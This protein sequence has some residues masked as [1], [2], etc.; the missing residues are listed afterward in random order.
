VRGSR[1]PAWHEHRPKATIAARLDLPEFARRQRRGRREIAA[2]GRSSAWLERQLWELDVAGSNPFAPTHLCE[3][4]A[5]S[6][7]FVLGY[8]IGSGSGWTGS[9]FHSLS[10]NCDGAS[11]PR[12]DVRRAG[13]RTM[14]SAIRLASAHPELEPAAARVLARDRDT[15]RSSLE[16]TMTND[17]SFAR[18]F[19]SSV[20]ASCSQQ[21]CEAPEPQRAARSGDEFSSVEEFWKPQLILSG[22]DGA[23]GQNL[24]HS[25]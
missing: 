16:P 6:M 17:H 22:G 9:A 18:R 25:Q 20:E 5:L 11:R 3:R 8:G 13:P 12:K 15:L 14:L 24:G 19:L 10:G 7:A 2:T 1:E 4:N 21:S 23:C